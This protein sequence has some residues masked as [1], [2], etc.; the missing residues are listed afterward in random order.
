MDV[1][2][3]KDP[4]PYPSGHKQLTRQRIVQ[5]AARLF[6]ARGFAAASIDAIMTDCGLTR[7]AFYAHFPSKAALYREA[8][9]TV[10]APAVPAVP[11]RG[12]A[13]LDRMLEDARAAGFRGTGHLDHWAFL[14]TDVASREP[15]VRA[16]YAQA[17]RRLGR[18][19]EDAPQQADAL[20]RAA[21]VVGLL[22]IAA[23]VDDER[24]RNAVTEAC[25]ERLERLRDEA[26]QVDPGR[27]LWWADTRG[28]SAQVCGLA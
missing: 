21:L 16:A 7:G 10:A 23:T 27:C 3:P 13:W 28:A 20:A 11:V 22:A 14:A 15:E 26:P 4:M 9:D 1:Q 5:S 24:L 17:L 6:A 12:A 8:M 19:L 18:Q 2:P 25:R